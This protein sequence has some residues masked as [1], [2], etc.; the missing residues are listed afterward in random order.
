MLTFAVLNDANQNP[1]CEQAQERSKEVQ[2][3][4]ALA[5]FTKT[6]HLHR[7]GRTAE[8]KAALEN[9]LKL[10]FMKDEL[11]P[12]ADI[13]GSPIHAAQYLVRKNYAA[14]LES[15]G[16]LQE[17][18][19]CLSHAVTIDPTDVSTC[20]KLGKLA[21]SL[22]DLELA[23]LAYEEAVKH[24][25][26]Y[27]R[28]SHL[29]ELVET[30]YDRGE[31]SECLRRVKQILA[32][33]PTWAR[34]IWL[35]HD[36]TSFFLQSNQ[37]SL[38]GSFLESSDAN[39]HHSYPA[40]EMSLLIAQHPEI[41]RP[42]KIILQNNS[43]I[44]RQVYTLHELTWTSLGRLLLCILDE[45]MKSSDPSFMV[46]APVEIDISPDIPT[47]PPEIPRLEVVVPPAVLTREPTPAPG[48]ESHKESDPQL[49]QCD[50]SAN[51][52]SNEVLQSSVVVAILDDTASEVL[53]NG[54][55]RR[56][57]RTLTLGDDDRRTSKRVK[58]KATNVE[59]QQIEVTTDWEM[60][61]TIEKWLPKPWTIYG[62]SQDITPSPVSDPDDYVSRV[63]GKLGVLFQMDFANSGRTTPENFTEADDPYFE[64]TGPIQSFLA[65]LP[66]NVDVITIMREY[67]V[68]RLTSPSFLEHRWPK[69]LRQTVLEVIVKLE[70]NNSLLAFMRNSYSGVWTSHESE[71]QSSIVA[72]SAFIDDSGIQIL[73]GVAELAIDALPP[74]PRTEANRKV[75]SNQLAPA[76]RGRPRID[77]EKSNTSTQ[78]PAALVFNHALA[79]LSALNIRIFA[80]PNLDDHALIRYLWFLARSSERGGRN[81]DALDTYQL[82]MDLLR[83]DEAIHLP[84]STVVTHLNKSSVMTKIRAIQSQSH[85]WRAQHDFDAKDYEAVANRLVPIL[86]FE[87]EQGV[88]ES[89]PDDLNDVQRLEFDV[90]VNARKYVRAECTFQQ[91]FRLNH[92]LHECLT[93]TGEGGFALMCLMRG[94]IDTVRNIDQV[95]ETN[96]ALNADKLALLLGQILQFFENH[97]FSQTFLLFAKSDCVTYK[98]FSFTMTKQVLC[99]FLSSIFLL[100]RLSYFIFKREDAILTSTTARNQPRREAMKLFLGRIWHFAVELFSFLYTD[101]GKQ[102]T[103]LLGVAVIGQSMDPETSTDSF[104]VDDNRDPM[105]EIVT[106]VHDLLGIN[107]T[108]CIEN[109]AV[110]RIG[111]THLKAVKHLHLYDREM[112]QIFYCLHGILIQIDSKIDEHNTVHKPLTMDAASECYDVLSDHILRKISSTGMS[113]QVALGLEATLDIIADAL[114]PLPPNVRLQ[115]NKAAIEKYLTSDIDVTAVLPRHCQRL[116]LWDIDKESISNVHFSIHALQ[117]KI[118]WTQ[119][120]S[121]KSTTKFGSEFLGSCLEHFSVNLRLNPH[122]RDGWISLGQAHAALSYERLAWSAKE[123]N[124]HRKEIADLQKK[125]F[126]CLVQGLKLKKD[127]SDLIYSPWGE[128][129]FL[130]DSIITNPMNG[131]ALR[132]QWIQVQKIWAE[133]EISI[134]EIGQQGVSPPRLVSDDF[135]GHFQ[136]S[137]AGLLRIEVWALKKR[138][139]ETATEWQWPLLMGKVYQKLRQSFNETIVWY[140]RALLLVPEEW[141]TKDQEHILD[142][143]CKFISYLSKCLHQNVIT[144]EIVLEKLLI[145]DSQ[146]KDEPAQ[147]Q[148][149]DDSRIHAFNR[150]CEELRRLKSLDKKRWQHKP[151][152][153]LAWIL[154]HVFHDVQAAKSE[155]AIMFQPKSPG[156]HF[157]NFWRPEFERPGK[158]YV[159]IEKYTVF[160]IHLLDEAGEYDILKLLTRKLRKSEDNLLSSQ[161]FIMAFEACLKGLKMQLEELLQQSPLSVAGRISQSYLERYAPPLQADIFKAL[162]NPATRDTVAE[163][164]ALLKCYEL[165]K[166]NEKLAEDDV[167]EEMMLSI[168]SGL[169]ERFVVSHV[170]SE[171]GTE[172]AVLPSTQSEGRLVTSA[173]VMKKI[174]LLCRNPPK[175][176]Q[177]AQLAE[178]EDG[179]G[180]A[181]AVQD[182]A[183]FND[184]SDDD[185]LSLVMQRPRREPHPRQLSL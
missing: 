152:Y 49:V 130:I 162:E 62:L 9:L 18:A 52:A 14:I 66:K 64:S 93:R 136:S 155:M 106:I 37:S 74:I 47:H 176:I 110:L 102:F 78:C 177:P 16:R 139:I 40:Q 1:G 77:R 3:E 149:S 8:A 147:S 75:V 63:G 10:D 32:V 46:G 21:K 24:S 11:T 34:G 43:V 112:Y 68:H 76:P 175:V 5:D 73:L 58:E 173:G 143:K 6:L 27:S 82:C 123:I 61:D 166:I 184:E 129:S 86:L 45:R 51:A 168:Y 65:A 29:R 105:S 185:G 84:N 88:V 158:H 126:L 160:Y 54:V 33:E 87:P 94:L 23:Q 15:E 7:Q 137:R 178:Q 142:V 135:E 17:A 144:P 169:L 153:R 81:E 70:E 146:L 20:L 99:I 116:Y 100:L 183:K 182:V 104:A 50:P 122:N 25:D 109:A 69:D 148:W 119:H 150:L 31:F 71:R 53:S 30:L 96:E 12:V 141:P 157:V 113:R 164:N 42:R 170:L 163:F 80:N 59:V 2:V 174:M 117:G 83:D 38:V 111:L 103:R 167:L 180:D 115:L 120:T 36:I 13:Q 118:A 127:K 154:Y 134:T 67:V 128:L 132:S 179:P 56:R 92:M 55:D 107:G 161:V 131:H 48:P 97:A 124:V 172:N 95:D 133:R 138:M 121:R 90:I 181:A 41:A 159:Y 151:Y 171:S 22:N 85:V 39:D 19:D 156:K 35:N 28:L 4:N 98:N 145:L 72:P 101:E 140:E 114:G 165:K 44:S 89:L 108:C 60:Q 26:G 125:A 79:F 91:R 57:R